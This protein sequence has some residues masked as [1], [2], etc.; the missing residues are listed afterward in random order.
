MV[1]HC[2]LFLPSLLHQSTKAILHYF[3]RL[4]NQPTPNTTVS[5]D[6]SQ[7][8]NNK[9]TTT[10]GDNVHNSKNR[11]RPPIHKTS[12][13]VN[14]SKNPLKLPH[15]ITTAT[16]P[17]SCP[18]A[19]ETDN[20]A[21]NEA[22]H[23]ANHITHELGAQ[24]A[25]G[26]IEEGKMDREKLDEDIVALR[27]LEGRVWDGGHDGGEVDCKPVR[28]KCLSEEG[29]ARDWRRR[30]VYLAVVGIVCYYIVGLGGVFYWL[31]SGIVND[32]R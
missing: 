21:W 14:N 23:F 26:Y 6:D 11:Q 30:F 27:E 32:G 28:R 12:P 8:S 16:L 18:S 5:S 3:T 31:V 9:R 29:R 4:F 20:E 13:S 22:W 17:I 7:D 1:F 25:G 10:I 19:F 2:L 15:T 24:V